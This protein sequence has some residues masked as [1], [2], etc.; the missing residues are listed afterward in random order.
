M[1]AKKAKATKAAAP[2]PAPKKAAPLF[3][4]TD[5]VNTKGVIALKWLK[6]I[7]ERRKAENRDCA[8]CRQHGSCRLGCEIAEA[9]R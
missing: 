9:L 8:C 1:A 3:Q 7:D 5:A 4:T 6:V 2:K